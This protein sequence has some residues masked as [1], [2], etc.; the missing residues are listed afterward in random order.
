MTYE[1]LEQ[2]ERWDTELKNKERLFVL[3]Y[4]GCSLSG[5]LFNAT[6]AYKN[7]YT[8]KLSN[9][10]VVFEPAQ[11]TCETNSSKLMKKPKIKK[12]IKLL[13]QEVRAE[14]DEKNVTKVLKTLETLAFFNPADIL[15]RRGRIVC[16]DLKEL[17]DNALAVAQIQPTLVGPK[18]QLVDR[19]KYLALMTRYLNI[20]RPE[21]KVEVDLPVIELPT[22]AASIEEWN[23]R[24][25]NG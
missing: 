12:A 11:S 9:G 25:S 23:E 2:E 20:V 16:D 10:E 3:Y 22:K 8:R 14:T 17:G 1:E 19:A 6:D 15:D 13:L 18:V 7:A 5:E 21:V 4:C 24:Y